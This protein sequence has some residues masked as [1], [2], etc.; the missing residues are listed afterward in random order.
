MNIDE[1]G[2]HIF[3]RHSSVCSLRRMWTFEIFFQKQTWSMYTFFK[4]SLSIH[5]RFPHSNF[6][7]LRISRC[8][9][10]ITHTPRSIR[11]GRCVQHQRKKNYISLTMEMMKERTVSNKIACCSSGFCWPWHMVGDLIRFK[12]ILEGRNSHSAENSWKSSRSEMGQ[13]ILRQSLTVMLTGLDSEEE[14]TTSILEIVR[15]WR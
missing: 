8:P 7:W 11:L 5:Q 14:W 12:M 6:W 4:W 2:T 13:S 10:E 1:C 15:E 9:H 3:C